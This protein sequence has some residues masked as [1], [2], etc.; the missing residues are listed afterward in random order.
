MEASAVPR[1]AP[2]GVSVVFQSPNLLRLAS[3]ARLVTLV[4]ERNAGAFETVY[5]RHHRAILSFCRHMLGD[6]Q[7]AEDAV[8]HTFLAAYSDLI[9][10]TKQIHLKAW[11]FTIAR[12]RCYSV[13][14][15]RREQ[16]SS[17]L[18]EA[19]TEGLAVQV[20]RRQDLRDLVIDMQRLPEDQRA[21]LVLAELDAL[22]HDEIAET[23]GVPQKKVKALVFQARE[24]LLASRVA[25]ETDCAD[26]REQLATQR[27][28]ALR[29]GN[30]RRHL[31]ECAGCRDFRRDVERQRHRL[32]VLLPVAPTVALREGVFGAAAGGGAAAGLSG[33]GGAVF[34]TALKSGLVKMSIGALAAGVG[35][36]GTIVATQDLVLPPTTSQHGHR[37]A[38][39]AALGA[40]TSGITA[41]VSRAVAGPAVPAA[42]ASSPALT[43]SVLSPLLS[44]AAP[45]PS[46]A[47][48]LWIRNA[49]LLSPRAA[50]K[51]SGSSVLVGPAV[52]QTPAPAP[53]S[54]A[55]SAPLTMA[56]APIA[57]A[58]PLP[59][60]PAPA[61]VTP[62]PSIPAPATGASK[63]PGQ[64]DGAAGNGSSTSSGTAHHTGTDGSSGWTSTYKPGATSGTPTG[65]TRGASGANGPTPG[66]S[67]G[68]TS[69]SGTKTGTTTGTTGTTSGTGTKTGTT[70]STGTTTG[71]GSTSSGSATSGGSHTSGSTTS[72]STT[73]AGSSTTSSGS[74][75]T[76]STASAGVTVTVPKTTTVGYTGT[77]R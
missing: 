27:G 43:R 23:L 59:A 69:G 5:N 53:P 44:T 1:A 67:T 32:A 56:T 48:S 37:H 22:S 42:P 34:S 7:E 61:T 62:P 3:D 40:A 70:G 6:A 68:T 19:V 21:A 25:R 2:A 12:N 4:R 63:A 18:D 51:R 71:S 77:P 35:T 45:I 33:A 50:H 57:A 29:R 10:S 52:P 55:S 15:G 14:R 76:S 65:T 60:P 31:R 66:G 49:S 38:A 20:Q 46:A 13:L 24:S 75:A 36:A 16:P 74:T 26:I 47:G 30:L 9:S 72:G 64:H 11:L 39:S 8:Q 41:A 58:T 73:A 54:L 28:G 17:D